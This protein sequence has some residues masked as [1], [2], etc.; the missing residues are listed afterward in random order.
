M[1]KPHSSFVPNPTAVSWLFTG[2]SALMAVQFCLW[3][4]YQLTRLYSRRAFQRQ[5]RHHR[6]LP[7]GEFKRIAAELRQGSLNSEGKLS[8]SDEACVICF[9]KP[10]NRPVELLPCGH[11]CFCA[12]CI[13]ELWKYSRQNE[14]FGQDGSGGSIFRHHTPL[15]CPLCRQVALFV[16][17]YSIRRVPCRVPNSASNNGSDPTNDDWHKNIKESPQSVEQIGKSD[18]DDVLLALRYNNDFLA[19]HHQEYVIDRVNWWEKT[20][21]YCIWWLNR[22]IHAKLLP[23]FVG[24]RIVLL[25]MTV[26]LYFILPSDQLIHITEFSYP[27]SS[28]TSSDGNTSRLHTPNILQRN[29]LLG[30]QNIS[31]NKTIHPQLNHKFMNILEYPLLWLIYYA[32]DILFVCSCWISIG[33]IS[34]RL[35]FWHTNIA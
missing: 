10:V 35:L 15:A 33:H 29:N 19:Q 22:I 6:L 34:N 4:S 13:V 5:L 20:L 21:Y 12:H 23:L 28:L 26:I 2:V 14:I 25:H 9:A 32:D 16:C 18:E 11:S 7:W 17:P 1:C 27:G 31:S 30:V 3:F 24:L 8:S